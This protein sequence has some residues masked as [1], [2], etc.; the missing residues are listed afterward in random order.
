MINLK[1][2]W[3]AWNAAKKILLSASY[4]PKDA[5]EERKAIHTKL[6]LPDSSKKLTPKQLD[7]FIAEASKINPAWQNRSWN[8]KRALFKEE[9]AVADKDTKLR[10]KCRHLAS[11]LQAGGQAGAED[12]I[13]TII[14][15]SLKRKA[16]IDELSG[17]DLARIANL[18]SKSTR[19]RQREAGIPTR[20]KRATPTKKPKKQTPPIIDVEVIA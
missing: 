4:T 17:D 16:M 2:Y 3:S 7:A 20:A 8:F 1:V 13:A 9:H 15:R 18:L 11:C 10:W 12:Y 5:E 6:R 19:A 14:E